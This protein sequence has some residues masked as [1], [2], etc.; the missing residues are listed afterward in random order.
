MTTRQKT[1]KALAKAVSRQSAVETIATAESDPVFALIKF[2]DAAR[3][4]FRSFN[5]NK[6]ENLPISIE[7]SKALEHA[8]SA[9][10]LIVPQTRAGTIAY[11]ELIVRH[12]TWAN[13]LLAALNREFAA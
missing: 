9:L 3:D 7:L 11:A 12:H 6:P 2:H 5:P 8:N 13:S 10:S 1:R 4:A